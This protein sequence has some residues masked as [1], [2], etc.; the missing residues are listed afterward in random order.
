MKVK[1]ILITGILLITSF[2]LFAAA[3]PPTPIDGGLSIL[4]AI[5]AIFGIKKLINSRNRK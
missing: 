1:K 5:G 2:Q 3:A 4:L